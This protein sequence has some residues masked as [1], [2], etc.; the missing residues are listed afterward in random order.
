MPNRRT[1]ST[2]RE[3][4]VEKIRQGHHEQQIRQRYPD[5][6]S[7]PHADGRHHQTCHQRDEAVLHNGI[8]CAHF[9]DEY[10]HERKHHQ[11]RARPAWAFVSRTE[12]RQPL[13][14]KENGYQ[15]YEVAVVVFLSFPPG[16]HEAE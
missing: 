1:T 4:V 12:L 9:A 10:Y 2:L 5:R 16:H 11:C 7:A 6:E 3:I 13:P 8:D 15:W 14:E